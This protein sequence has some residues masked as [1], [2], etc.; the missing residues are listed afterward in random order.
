MKYRK[1]N[2]EQ[3]YVLEALIDQGFSNRAMA[4]E[5]G[6]HRTTIWRE[7]QRHTTKRGPDKGY[8][9][10]DTAQRKA[11]KRE[12]GKPR[13]IKWTR[14]LKD[15][16]KYWMVE[17][18]WSPLTGKPRAW[19]GFRQ[20][21]SIAGDGLAS[22]GTKHRRLPTNGGIFIYVMAKEDVSVGIT[23]GIEEVFKTVHRC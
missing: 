13:L 17:E 10:A 20:N 15:D 5:L 2:Q 3:R 9:Q 1:L 8:Y 16:I 11:V 4:E 14:A 19:Q 12:Q 18:R 22:T 7:R 6:V 21:A 23:R